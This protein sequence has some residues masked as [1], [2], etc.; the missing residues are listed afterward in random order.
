MKSFVARIALLLA[1]LLAVGQAQVVINEIHYDPSD[2]TKRAEFVELHNANAAPVNVG[3]WQLDDAVTFVFPSNTVI[4]AGGYLVVAENASA[5]QAEFGVVAG[6]V[7]IGSLSN[8]GELFQLKDLNAVLQDEVTYGVGFPW[9]TKAK[10]GGGSMELLNPALDNDL[11]GSWRTSATKGTPGVQN[12]VFAQNAPPAIRQVQH[13]PQQP[14]ANVPV[15]ITA[16]VTDP[17]GVGSV[18]L[19]YQTVNPGAYIRKT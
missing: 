11:G 10:G 9:P 14:T 8:Q 1:G 18:T 17:D 12:S 16:K 5:F 2:R 13:V 7:F 3:G 6:G 4:P 15:L 19:S